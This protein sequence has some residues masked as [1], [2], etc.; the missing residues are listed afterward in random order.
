[1]RT[2]P[3]SGAWAGGYTDAGLPPDLHQYLR[4]IRFL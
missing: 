3:F 2:D 4:K 1:M